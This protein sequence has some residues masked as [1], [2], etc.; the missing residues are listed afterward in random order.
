MKLLLRIQIPKEFSQGGLII[1]REVGGAV[2]DGEECFRIGAVIDVA[3]DLGPALQLRC[4]HQA[5]AREDGAIRGDNDGFL[6][7]MY[8]QALAQ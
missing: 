4:L 1:F 6:L 7:A 3:G 2:V 5:V 8:T